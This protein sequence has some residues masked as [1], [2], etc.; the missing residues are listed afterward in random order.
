[1]GALDEW[2]KEEFPCN[3]K[4]DEIQDEVNHIFYKEGKQS[5]IEFIDFVA[6]KYRI[7]LRNHKID[8]NHDLR[9]A[10]LQSMNIYAIVNNSTDD[11]TKVYDEFIAQLIYLKNDLGSKGNEGSFNENRITSFDSMLNDVGKKSL[12]EIKK[13][14]PSYNKDQHPKTK[15]FAY[16]IKVLYDLKLTD[17]D[18]ADYPMEELHK[19]M[20]SF[21]GNIGTRQALSNAIDDLKS[22]LAIGDNKAVVELNIHKQRL[23]S[24]LKED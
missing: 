16:L 1:M 3:F 2:A 6:L 4:L 22:K 14:Y 9:F 5:A 19:L 7:A 12:P 15:R 13:Q 11:P 8:I 18:L 24:I 20:T 17:S 10:H 23:E 21:F